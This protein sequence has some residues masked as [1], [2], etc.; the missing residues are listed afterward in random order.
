MNKPLK[1][2]VI[3]SLLF[4]FYAESTVVPVQH[5]EMGTF[6]IAGNSV[7]S[8]VV[9]D[10]FGNVTVGGEFREIIRGS[11]GIY[12]VEDLTPNVTYQVSINV[13]NT[14]MNPGQASLEYFDFDIPDFDETVLTDDNGDG[15]IR[16]GGRITKSG[17]GGMDFANASYVSNIVVSVFQ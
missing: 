5:V 6:A 15:V 3:L 17:S 2:F 10:R 1:V 8:S 14:T 16:V 13:V 7:S 4:S 11:P 9:I 12:R